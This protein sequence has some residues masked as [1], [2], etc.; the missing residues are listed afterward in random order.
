MQ[1]I[2]IDA[3]H[4]KASVDSVLVAL[5]LLM[6]GTGL[7]VLYSASAG[8]AQ[9]FFDDAAYFLKKQSL[10]MGAG[11]V[12]LLIC[13]WLPLESLRKFI[14]PLMLV[15]FLLCIL[16]FVPGI[17]LTKNG[18]ARW[19]QLGPLSYQPSELVKLSLPIYL[20]HILSKK[21]GRLAEAAS[22]VLPPALITALFCFVVYLQND[23]STSVFLAVNAIL[24]F[25][26]AGVR[27]RHFIMLLFISVPLAALFVFTKAHRVM[28]L[29]SFLHPEADPLGAGYQL[30]S[31]KEALASGALW[32]KG[33]GAGVRKLASVPEVHSDF[34]F[35]AYAEETG[36][37]GVLVFFAVLAVFCARV[38][39]I[40]FNQDDMYRR[41][42]ASALLFA[43][44]GQALLNIAV[45]G[46]IIPVTGV[47]L[48]FF[49]AG[50][51]SLLTVMASCGLLINMSR[52]VKKEGEAYV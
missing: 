35:A 29:L 37:F 40:I 38:A 52:N 17:A 21:Q 11:L 43:I 30:R 45:V 12:L 27:I 4:R 22:G 28:R 14:L 31:S 2:H 13:A 23:F 32:G 44:A 24:V 20:S 46:G 41:L 19:I 42:L 10:F 36:L 7:V 18:A 15:S 1:D 47:P 33:L 48:P 50:G 26:L 5:V 9:R 16:S 3:V 8:F 34:V 25:F 49:S 6:A 51:S 39:R